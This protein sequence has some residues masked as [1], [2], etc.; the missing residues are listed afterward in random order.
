MLKDVQIYLLKSLLSIW[1]TSLICPSDIFSNIC[2]LQ[3]FQILRSLGKS[4]LIHINALLP[5]WLICWMLESLTKPQLKSN[6]NFSLPPL[7]N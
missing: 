2:L 1:K 5:L 7:K 6:K 4:L 3:T